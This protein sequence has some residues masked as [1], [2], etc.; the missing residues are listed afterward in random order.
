MGEEPLPLRYKT[1]QAAIG[2]L[3]QELIYFFEVF[4][5]NPELIIRNPFFGDL[6]F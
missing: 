5:K 2:K 6:E 3:Q 1:V 4:E